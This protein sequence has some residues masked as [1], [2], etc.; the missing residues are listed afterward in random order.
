MKPVNCNDLERILREAEPEALHALE[1]HAENCAACREELSLWREISA[2]AGTMHREWE[3]PELWPRIR[4]RLAEES[5][6]P[7][8]ESLWRLLEFWRGWGPGWQMAGTLALLL[9]ISAS[10]LW[11]ATRY[12]APLGTP[13]QEKMAVQINE[14]EQRLLTEET[15]REVEQA[16]ALYLRSIDRLARLAAA[17]MEKSDSPLVASY[18]EKLLVLDSAIAELRAQAEDNRFNAHLRSELLSL[19]RDKAGTLEA[20]LR[21]PER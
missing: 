19:Y 14:E 13:P 16:E 2:A 12:F 17:K 6:A 7:Q 11:M 3:S 5:Q 15:L 18:R 4:Q 1:A 9:V 10:S 8:R 20:V 21:E